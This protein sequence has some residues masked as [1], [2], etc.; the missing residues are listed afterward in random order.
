MKLKYINITPVKQLLFHTFL[1]LWDGDW[2]QLG[3][4]HPAHDT[5]SH[6]RRTC[7]TRDHMATGL[8]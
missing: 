7:P 6:Q 4:G 3:N 5:L 2:V 1:S 8:Y